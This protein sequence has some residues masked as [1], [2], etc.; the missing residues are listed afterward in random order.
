VLPFTCFWESPSASTT[1]MGR[2]DERCGKVGFR[3]IR[4][5]TGIVNP[6]A[7]GATTVEVRLLYGGW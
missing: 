2:A 5:G 1:L 7:R 3:E 6:L 4:G